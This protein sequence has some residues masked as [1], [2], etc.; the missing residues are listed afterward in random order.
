MIYSGDK[1]AVVWKDNKP[2][3][4]ASNVDLGE[5]NSTVERYVREER[6]K[7]KVP[8]PNQI[9]AYN[10]HMGGVDLLDQMVACYRYY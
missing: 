2:V 8:M 3:Y 4:V 9:K 6:K 5:G 10:T 7:V 1:M